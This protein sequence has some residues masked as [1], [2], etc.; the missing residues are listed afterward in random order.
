MKTDRTSL[1]GQ[2][3]EQVRGLSLT[4]LSLNGLSTL[5]LD[6]YIQYVELVYK[7]VAIYDMFVYAWNA[8]FMF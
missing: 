7:F 2:Y 3:V 4:G 6:L 1:N 8:Q 5:D